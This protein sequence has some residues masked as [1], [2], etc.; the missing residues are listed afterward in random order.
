MSDEDLWKELNP[1]IG[2]FERLTKGNV[3]LGARQGFFNFVKASNWTSQLK[4][5]MEKVLFLMKSHDFLLEGGPH[6]L[7][8]LFHLKGIQQKVGIE[9]RLRQTALKKVSP[10]ILKLI[11]KPI[12]LKVFQEEMEKE[13]VIEK[14]EPMEIKVKPPLSPKEI[15][16]EEK[17]VF[18][19]QQ[20]SEAW[21]TFLGFKT[22]EELREFHQFTIEDLKKISIIK[23]ELE[24][25]PT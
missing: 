24:Q 13:G 18:F 20:K 14:K 17:L 9:I 25:Y 23:K 8:R 10:P 12:S 16:V 11:Q 5:D 22:M 7:K 6:Y 4:A 1:I 21:R 19:N 2:E 15:L 3:G